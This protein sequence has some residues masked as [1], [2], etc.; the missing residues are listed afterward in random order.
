MRIGKRLCNIWLSGNSILA[1]KKKRLNSFSRALAPAALESI[2]PSS[3]TTV[4][5]KAIFL[6]IFFKRKIKLD[7]V[8]MGDSQG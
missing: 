7:N 1:K 5:N 2:L 4:S 6:T 3:V 8:Q